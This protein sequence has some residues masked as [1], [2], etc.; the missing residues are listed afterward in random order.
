MKVNVKWNKEFFKDIE[1]DVDQPPAVFKLQLFSLTNVDPDRMKIL[2]K[3]GI[4]GDEEWGKGKPKDGQTLMMMGTVSELREPQG[5]EIKFIEDVV[6]EEE[7][8]HLDTKQ[9]GAGLENM[10]NTCYMNSTMQCLYSVKELRE[11]LIHSETDDLGVGAPAQ[12]TKEV[13][14]LFA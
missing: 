8:Q 2:V 13:K 1:V 12:L 9:Y 4:L 14:S 6:G 11:Q 10:G 7:Q 5:D 3:G